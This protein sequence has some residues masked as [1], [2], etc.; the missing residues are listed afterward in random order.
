MGGHRYADLAKLLISK[1]CSTYNIILYISIIIA[2][3]F[4]VRITFSSHADDAES[5][6][7]HCYEA[8]CKLSSEL[9]Y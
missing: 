2:S 4:A 9:L 6:D 7:R 8:W 3:E 1:M 5:Y